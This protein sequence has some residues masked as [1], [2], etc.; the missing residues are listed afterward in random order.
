MYV[1]R[2]KTDLIEH[3]VFIEQRPAFINQKRRTSSGGIQK[4]NRI[5]E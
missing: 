3:Y 5:P 1:P 4:G 2:T